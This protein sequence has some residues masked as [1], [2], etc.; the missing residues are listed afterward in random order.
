MAKKKTTGGIAVGTRVRVK[1][2][3]TA[4]EFP[5]VSCGGW[6]GTVVDVTGARSAEPKFVIEWD[7]DT[8]AAM[9]ESYR[10]QC[11]QQNLLS[12]MACLPRDDFEA[13]T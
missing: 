4:P 12:T 6:T 10:T 7:G 5:D 2:D 9:P 3:V 1:P 11:E 13:I 8:L